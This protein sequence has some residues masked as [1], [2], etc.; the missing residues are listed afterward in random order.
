MM[1]PTHNRIAIA[2][3]NQKPAFRSPLHD[4]APP[5]ASFFLI[6]GF[7]HMTPGHR[8]KTQ[9]APRFTLGAV[10]FCFAHR[11]KNNFQLYVCL[12]KTM[13]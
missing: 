1:T 13:V 4:F 3:S 11:T 9:S 5:I 10:F 7:V 12:P 8:T 6:Q 2:S